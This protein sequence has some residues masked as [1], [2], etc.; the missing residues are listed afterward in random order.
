MITYLNNLKI[1]MLKIK[2]K[3]GQFIQSD[4]VAFIATV[5]SIL[6]IAPIIL[7]TI[8]SVSDGFSDALGNMSA[9]EARDRVDGI[10]N[11]FVT[12][13]DYIIGIAFLFNVIAMFIFAFGVSA[14]PI[15][16]I[17]YLITAVFTLSF[18]NYVVSPIL[19][20]FGMDKFAIEAGELP[21]VFFITQHFAVIMLFIIMI[22]GV[23]MF[24]RIGRGQQ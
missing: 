13:W 3:R 21:I 17:F 7:L 2:N 19:H 22:T 11:T 8:N 24:T 23:I 18:S 4:I 20:I 5:V 9:T 16:S 12:F 6:I 1:K 14:H 15:W 10:Q